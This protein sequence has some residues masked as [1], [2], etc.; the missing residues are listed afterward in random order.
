MGVENR[1]GLMTILLK[2]RPKTSIL[3]G[4]I[5]RQHKRLPSLL[6]LKF[7]VKRKKK[8]IETSLFLRMLYATTSYQVDTKSWC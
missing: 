6:F 8:F 3:A 5:R 7:Q 1:V 4:S 2:I